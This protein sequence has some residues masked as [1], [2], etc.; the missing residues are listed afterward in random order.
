[1]QLDPSAYIYLDC[2]TEPSASP[3][4]IQLGQRVRATGAIAGGPA[5]AIV[6]SSEVRINPGRATVIDPIGSF[7]DGAFV[8]WMSSISEV[9]GFGG[10]VGEEAEL[11]FFPETDFEGDVSSLE[12]FETVVG[13]SA[14][15]ELRIQGIAA[16]GLNAIEVYE[17]D[18]RVD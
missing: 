3:E 6:D 4:A 9:E 12:E 2:G 10:S 15:I 16:I 17:V 5:E 18:V 7:E 13:G 8:V 14:P 11:Y 1:V